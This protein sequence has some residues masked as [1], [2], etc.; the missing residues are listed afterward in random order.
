MIPR[1]APH[2]DV[3]TRQLTASDG[4]ALADLAS[5]LSEK[6]QRLRFFVS[7]RSQTDRWVAR[8]LQA[9]QVDH[10][11]EC[12]VVEDIF[13]SVLVGVAEVVRLPDDPSV[14]ELGI[15]VVD[16]WQGLGAGTHLVKAVVR[17]AVSAGI[18]R[19][20]ADRLAENAR[21]GRTLNG[22]GVVLHREVGQGIVTTTHDLTEYEGGEGGI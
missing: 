6:S 20:R 7:S 12:L 5:R 14:G 18:V 19:L 22:I 16:D 10:L 3:I 4:S 21:M 9:D 8:L 17:R 13:G 11:V 2:Q 1:Q 15:A